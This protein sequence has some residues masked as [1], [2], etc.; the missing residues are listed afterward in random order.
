MLSYLIVS[1]GCFLNAIQC[2]HRSPTESTTP[3]ALIFNYIDSSYDC[4]M[5]SRVS[6]LLSI[7]FSILFAIMAGT[8][9][10]ASSLVVV[11]RFIQKV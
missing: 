7:I 1:Y 11:R 3:S 2:I 10:G 6:I 8:H 5:A 9:A 4:I